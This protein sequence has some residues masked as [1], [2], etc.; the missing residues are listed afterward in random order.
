MRVS[1][2]PG[3]AL[4]ALRVQ[5]GTGATSRCLYTASRRRFACC[6]YVELLQRWSSL[7]RTNSSVL[8]LVR[9]GGPLGSPA[10]WSGVVFL[11][12][13]HIWNKGDREGPHPTSAPPLP[14]QRT[15]LGRRF[16][17]SHCKGGSGADVGWGPSRSPCW[18]LLRRSSTILMKFRDTPSLHK[19]KVLCFP[20]RFSSRVT[21]YLECTSA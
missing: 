4:T 11:S 1:S 15:S 17:R 2:E 3:L 9:I 20:P 8:M 18:F 21:L 6:R 14:L 10:G 7:A 16:T 19:E 12:S 13:R 5:T